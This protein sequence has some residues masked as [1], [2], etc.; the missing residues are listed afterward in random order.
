[1]SR[2]KHYGIFNFAVDAFLT[3]FTGGLWLI[4]IYVRENRNK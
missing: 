4:W 2:R 1:M 3:L